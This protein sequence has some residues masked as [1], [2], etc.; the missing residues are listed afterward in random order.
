MLMWFIF[1]GGLKTK[2]VLLRRL[3]ILQGQEVCVMCDIDIETADHLFL[4]C[5]YASKLWWLDVSW[6]SVVWVGCRDI[7]GQ[8]IDKYVVGG[9]ITNGGDVVRCWFGEQIDVADWGEEFVKGL[10][11]SLQFMLEE[12][13]AIEEEITMVIDRKDIVEWLKGESKTNWDCRFL[14]NKI[15]NVTHLLK[16]INV[17]YM[18]PKEFRVR[19]QWESRAQACDQFWSHWEF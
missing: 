2:D 19:R 18:Q 15:L 7:R 12:M 9:V 5:P 4:H 17:V 10:E 11:I 1:S 14:R 13:N 3:V 6:G 16:N 8:D